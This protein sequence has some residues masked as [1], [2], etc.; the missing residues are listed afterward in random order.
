[1][2]NHSVKT[3]L[4]LICWSLCLVAVA[5]PPGESASR[6]PAGGDIFR[7]RLD[8]I[9]AAAVADGFGGGVAVQQDDELLYERTAGFS[10]DAGQVPVTDATL[11]HVASITKYFTACLV[12]VAAEEG[13]LALADT[14]DPLVEGSGLAG[15]DITFAKLL[16]HRSGLRSSYAAEN[17]YEPSA[18]LTAIGRAPW[19]AEDAGGFH[20]SNDGYDVLAIL[21]ERIY[22]RPY[23]AL[24]RE[25]LGARAGLTAIGFWGES[26]LTDPRRVGQPLAPLGA[27]FTRRNYGMIGSAGLL[28]TARELT[29]FERALESRRVLTP[30]SLAA[31]HAP[32]GAMSLGQATFG[33]FLVDHPVLGRVLSA[34]GAEDWGDNAIL[35][36]YLDR[37]LLLAVVTSRG[38]AEGEGERFRNRI[39]AAIERV[40]GGELP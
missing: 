34:R 29:R 9:V 36:H 4:F 38:P 5:A 7:A 25:K 6:P 11:F 3:R 2:R 30:A 23:E 22:G 28:V 10:D 20:Y 35:N 33:A 40:L 13:R 31:L 15:R 17:V 8:A 32:R 21:L 24:A 18:A 1:M 14:I 12:L 26:A 39:S 27:D 19:N 37:G 16:A